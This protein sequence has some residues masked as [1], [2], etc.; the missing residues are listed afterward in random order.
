[1]ASSLESISSRSDF[2]LI[3][4]NQTQMGPARAAPA[5]NLPTG[6]SLAVG[7]LNTASEFRA[8]QKTLKLWK[9]IAHERLG[10]SRAKEVEAPSAANRQLLDE[11]RESVRQYIMIVDLFE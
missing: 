11:D 8:T 2:S 10:Y 4:A 9:E 3:N 6:K 5:L 7:D 1:M